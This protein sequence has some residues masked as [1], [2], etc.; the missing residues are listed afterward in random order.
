[1]N[2]SASGQRR[3]PE[4]IASSDRPRRKCDVVMKGGITSGIV[5]PLAIARLASEYT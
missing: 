5:Y 2:S 3:V 4:Q 1:V